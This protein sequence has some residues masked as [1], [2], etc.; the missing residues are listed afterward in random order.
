MNIWEHI[1]RLWAPAAPHH[2]LTEAERDQMATNRY[3]E[4]A[5]AAATIL[6]HGDPNITS[7]SGG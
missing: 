5:N 3:D 4:A 6:S 1:K 7:G 2:P